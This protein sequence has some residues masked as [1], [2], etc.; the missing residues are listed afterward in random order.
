MTVLY[1]APGACS[2][3]AHSLINELQLPIHIELVTLG[4]PD[5]TIHRI[6][7]L[8]R[9]PAL[10]LDDGTLLTENSAIL[11]Y[12]ADLAPQS[13]VFA[14][15]GSTERAQIQ[16]WVGYITSEVHAGGFRVYNRAERYS[17]DESAHAGIRARA[18][19][20]LHRILAHI[21]RHLE[22]R[23]YLVGDRYTIA[24]AY[25]GV[26]TRAL[27]RLGEAFA[28][29]RNLARVREVFLSRPATV[30]ALAAEE[31]R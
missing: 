15:L 1:V 30:K 23:D 19:E 17:A 9:V 24:D 20:Q 25:L 31:V 8:G 6:N 7:P 2:I 10:S 22:G 29:L 28:D 21:D 12:L 3:A 26:F 27:P 13:G 18:A 5:A 16:S 14:P 4:T 11:P